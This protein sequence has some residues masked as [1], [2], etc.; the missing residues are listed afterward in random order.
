MKLKTYFNLLFLENENI[1]FGLLLIVSQTFISVAH[2]FSAYLLGRV[3]D[4]CNGMPNFVY[5]LI[6]LILIALGIAIFTIIRENSRERAK[7]HLQCGLRC[8]M[9]K[10][11]FRDSNID[12]KKHGKIFELLID[13]TGELSHDAWQIVVKYVEITV[14]TGV[15]MFLAFSMN[16]KISI[17]V[18]ITLP[19]LTMVTLKAMSVA[20]KTHAQRQNAE[21]EY[22]GV[23]SEMSDMK[24]ELHAFPMRKTFLSKY[25]EVSKI[26]YGADIK[27][28]RAVFFCRSIEKVTYIIG[29]LLVLCIGIS[30][31]RQGKISFGE[32]VSFM[33]YVSILLEQLSQINY[34]YDMW[35]SNRELYRSMSELLNVPDFDEAALYLDTPITEIE[36]KDLSF[37]YPD[38][39][40]EIISHLSAHFSHG[41]LIAL[42]GV[43]GV[44]KSTFIKLLLRQLETKCGEIL[45]NGIDIKDISSTYIR[46]EI[47]YLA[48]VPFILDGSIYENIKWAVPHL[49]REKAESILQEVGLDNIGCDTQAGENGENLSGGERQRLALA[50][51]IAKDSGTLIFDE[52]FAQLDVKNEKIIT[53]YITHEKNKLIILSTHKLDICKNASKTIKLGR[54]DI[55]EHTD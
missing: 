19:C 10:G 8:R 48:Q 35:I 46:D 47:A 23:V 39:I 52:P 5:D 40:N 28:K 51:C 31:Q 1:L 13:Q 36:I 20:T 12:S 7:T 24:K 2:S 21:R 33:V 18:V 9:L 49:S 34:I 55:C 22:T 38:N 29:Y 15:S 53:D 30:E 44:G 45:I 32:I 14:T 4:S 11:F 43:S 27:H 16:T 41:D 54:G 3:I 50:R 6:I 26:K 37:R 25:E 17:I 42:V